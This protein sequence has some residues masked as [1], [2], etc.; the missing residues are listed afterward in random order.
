MLYNILTMLYGIMFAA[1]VYVEIVIEITLLLCNRM[2]EDF[3][4]DFKSFKCMWISMPM[5][6]AREV[7]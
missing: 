2:H 3:N 1:I 4:N 7:Q 6:M 5:Y